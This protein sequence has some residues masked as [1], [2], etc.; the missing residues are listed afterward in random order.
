MQ[1]EDLFKH[2]GNKVLLIHKNGYKYKFLLLKSC[3]KETT[4]SFRD[5]FDNLVDINIEDISI[6]T[7]SNDEVRE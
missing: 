7:T 2:I 3:I 5:K 1:R 6:I 4:I